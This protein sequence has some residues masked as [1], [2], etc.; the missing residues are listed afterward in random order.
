MTPS[1]S[2]ASP[3]RCDAERGHVRPRRSGDEEDG[4]DGRAVDERGAEV[5]LQED[6][7][8]RDRAEPERRQRRADLVQSTRPLGE[9]AGERQ[10]EQDFPNSEG[11][12]RKKPRSSQRFEPRIAAREED[13]RIRN[14]VPPKIQRQRV[15]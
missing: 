3:S 9:E 6:Q 5:G 1:T 13:D 14:D 15:R 8:D 10:H 2:T 7:E 4:A 12:K 11:W